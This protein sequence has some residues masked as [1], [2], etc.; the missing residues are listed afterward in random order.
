MDRGVLDA[1]DVDPSRIAS[2]ISQRQS[3]SGNRI[4][5]HIKHWRAADYAI[6]V[7]GYGAAYMGAELCWR[8]SPIL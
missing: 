3:I 7:D 5:I 8:W 6:A 4:L 1:K 2:E